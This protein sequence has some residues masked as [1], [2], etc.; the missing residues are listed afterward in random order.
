[1]ER[2]WGGRKLETH[3][4][5][6]LPDEGKP[7]G[8]SW[9]VVDRE[10]EQSVVEGGE[11]A[12]KSLHELWSSHRE[13]IFGWGLPSSERFPLLLK[14]L[15]AGER[16]S[17]QVHPPADVARHLGGEPKTEM[18]Y[19]AH[20]DPG[21]EIFAGLCA[22]VTR[23]AFERGS[24]EGIAASQVHRIAVSPGDFIF[25]PSGRLHA[26]GGGLVIFEVQEN[27]DTTYRVYDWGRDGLDGVPRELH[28]S[29]SMQCIDFTDYEPGPGVAK[30]D[31]L[32]NCPQFRVE[33]WKLTAGEGRV[34]GRN[35]RFAL[36][37]VV[38]GLLRCG[39]RNFAAGDFFLVPVGCEVNLVT[40]EGA[41]LLHVTL[42]PTQEAPS[43]SP[44][45]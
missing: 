29:E 17:V 11:F 14:I 12:G 22:G 24:R 32:V 45:C 23:E 30:G 9:E 36:L 41:I 40:D 42:P 15:D 33:R 6:H 43:F 5:R 28:V 7:F 20:A 37:A 34:A 3:Y 19:V 35:G 38:D 26:I 18:W 31:L 8:E 10:G 1:M 2:V 13:Q 27:S 16:L 21:A 25:I 39:E 4:G 44:D